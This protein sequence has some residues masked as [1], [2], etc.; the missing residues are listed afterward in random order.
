MASRWPPVVRLVLLGCL[1]QGSAKAA[2]PDLWS[3]DIARDPRECDAAVRA[4]PRDLTSWTCY[5]RY[6]VTHREQAAALLQR[7]GD[8][9]RRDPANPFAT[10]TEGWMQD[11][12]GDPRGKTSYLRAEELFQR[13]GDAYGE[14]VAAISRLG[15]AAFFDEDASGWSV[16]AH[17]VAVAGRSGLPEM[18]A[19]AHTYGAEYA[20]VQADFGRAQLLVEEAR[21]EL[22]PEAPWWLLYRLYDA[23]GRALS[24]TGRHAEALESFDQARAQAGDRRFFRSLVAGAAA[25]EAVHLYSW[26]ELDLAEAERRIEGA[27]NLLREDQVKIWLT[28]GEAATQLLQAALRGPSPQSAAAVENALLVAQG[29]QPFLLGAALRLRAR[30]G[31]ESG[32]PWPAAHADATKAAKVGQEF[33]RPADLALGLLTASYVDWKAGRMEELREDGDRALQ[34]V[35]RIRRTQ[36]E[37]LV[38]AR[39]SADWA[40]AYELLSGWTLD[41]AGPDPDRAA[42][43]RALAIMER[44]R[45]QVLLDSLVRS[46]V[47]A[48]AIP[49]ELELRRA[50]AL[51]ALVHAQRTL[52][53]PGVDGDAR[54]EA[55]SRVEAEERELEVVDELIARATPSA[56]PAPIASLDAL[57][58]SLGA[59][60][61][62]LS[63]H[64]WHRDLSLD[65]PYP[66]GRS[67]LVVLTRGEAFAVRVADA[68]ELEPQ[69][70]T[71]LSIISQPLIPREPGGERLYRSLMATA[72][73]RLSTHVRH[74]IV[75]PDGPLHRLPLETLRSEDGRPLLER[76]AFSVVPSATLWERWR[77]KPPVLAVA[78]LSMA[79]PAPAGVPGVERGASGWLEKLQLPSLPH[80]RAESEGLVRAMGRGSVLRTG[81]AA[82]EHFL[83]TTNLL[84]WGLLHFA[85]HAVVDERQPERSAVVLAPGDLEQDGL[86]QPR[87]IAELDLHD[88]V[89]ILSG[90]RTAGGTLL[91]GEGPLGLVRAFFQA[92]A[93]SVIASPWPLDDRGARELMEELARRLRDGE[94]LATALADA[95][96]TLLRAGAPEASWAGLQL[97]GDGTVAF[98]RP[99]IGRFLAPLLAILGGVL[100][101]LAVLRLRGRRAAAAPHSR[102]P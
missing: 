66:E 68:H 9:V 51:R 23:Q 10:L 59:D 84:P 69:V 24:A 67:W 94:N 20:I 80:A 36:P 21:R 26:G 39:T 40:F 34:V 8:I 81:D 27:L 98:S 97:Y 60:E 70:G 48:P 28:R 25:E 89:V 78:A 56:E 18:V 42:I 87:E 32:I 79:D 83:K 52:V 37:P 6:L 14:G 92:G 30:L 49:T 96:R 43:T 19:W 13:T 46:G 64:L 47:S 35:D 22:T 54:A 17:A 15:S 55:G 12:I 102:L 93:R 3:G 73:G 85:T 90:C 101:V 45:G 82:S 57:Q 86:L 2:L 62:L 95:K 29:G 38:R 4:R 99:R 5:G 7:M 50:K 11:A 72:L 100:G 53:Q 44:W 88:R 1:L 71:Y 31:I 77:H 75:V 91:Q 65:A 76:Y 63:F 58:A 41:L 61:A 16:Y 33:A 74:L